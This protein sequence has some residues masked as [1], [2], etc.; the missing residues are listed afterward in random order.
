MHM[1]FRWFGPAD[2]IPLAHIQHIPGVSGVVSA[3][4]DVPVGAVWSR[5][6][7]E[8]LNS[9]I[10]AAGLTLRA[11]ERISRHQGLKARPPHPDRTIPRSLEIRA[12]PGAPTPSVPGHH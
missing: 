3:L 6:R 2:P 8:R 4:Y 10:E 5:E 7:L 11:V 1:T 9:E 12:P